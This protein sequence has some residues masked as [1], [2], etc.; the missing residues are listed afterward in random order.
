MILS[1]FVNFLLSLIPLA[2]F[3]VYSGIGFT[4]HLLWLPVIMF[5]QL[6]LVLG[7]GFFLSAFTVFYRDAMMVLDVVILGLFFMTPIFYP[8]ELIQREATIFNVTLPIYRMVRWLNPMA[9][10]IDSYRTVVYGVIE[11]SPDGLPIYYPPS[12]P[13]LDFMLRTGLTAFII[14][15]MGWSFFRFVS[16]RFGEEA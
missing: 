10:L 13:A 15:L 5:I 1:S 11:Y 6:L 9:S 4:W 7:L 8:M 2:F 16:P 3:L 12:A 14:F